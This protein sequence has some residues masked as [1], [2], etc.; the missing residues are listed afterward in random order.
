MLAEEEVREKARIDAETER[1]RRV[2]EHEQNMQRRASHPQRNQPQR[3]PQHSHRTQQQPQRL[4]QQPQRPSVVGGW[5]SA[6][7]GLAVPNNT[8]ANS[9]GKR[10]DNSSRRKSFLGLSFGSSRGSGGGGGDVPASTAPKKKGKLV[11]KSSSMW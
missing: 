11:K 5:Y 4:P 2:Y 1:L 7:G 6:P 8:S 9:N 10:L 3:V